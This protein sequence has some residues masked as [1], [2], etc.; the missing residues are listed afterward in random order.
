MAPR[1][2]TKVQRST[3][4]AQTG[5]KSGADKREPEAKAAGTKAAGAT[6]AVAST[7]ARPSARRTP[8]A[9][10]SVEQERD[11]LKAALEAAQER[12]KALEDAQTLVS[13]RIGWMID[14]LQS[15]KDEAP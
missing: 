12:I 3:A 13:N 5:A 10:I 4:R 2:K 7:V 6:A 1:D 11:D 9:S 14:T 15:L 8:L